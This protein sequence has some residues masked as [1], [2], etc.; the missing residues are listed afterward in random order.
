LRFKIVGKMRDRVISKDVILH[1][2]GTYGTEVAVNKNVEF[3]GPTVS[4]WSLSSRITVANMAAEINAEFA[5]FEADQK[6]IAPPPFTSYSFNDYRRERNN[7]ATFCTA[8]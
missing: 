1:I 8:T 2:A 7:R 5:L 6:V 3:T 4:V